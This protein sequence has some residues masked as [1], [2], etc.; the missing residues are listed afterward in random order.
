QDNSKA[1][2]TV[3]AKSYDEVFVLPDKAGLPQGWNS[4]GV[5]WKDGWVF[6][7]DGAYIDSPAYDLSQF[8]SLY[9]AFDEKSAKGR[10][11]IE[12][13][14]GDKVEEYFG[15]STNVEG[16]APWMWN[17]KYLVK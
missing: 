6:D 4:K 14:E 9:V 2:G 16:D 15:S 10:L 3:L 1:V 17:F 7:G 13:R 5:S 11:R 8:E 12:V